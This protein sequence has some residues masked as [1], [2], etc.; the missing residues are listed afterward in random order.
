MME[1]SRQDSYTPPEALVAAAN[2]VPADATSVGFT[3]NKRTKHWAVIWHN[4]ETGY[5]GTWDSDSWGGS[6][7]GVIL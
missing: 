7:Y 5:G 6:D 1:M 2:R 4:D 3:Y